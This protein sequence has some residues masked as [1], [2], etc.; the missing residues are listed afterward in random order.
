MGTR[1]P[2]VKTEQIALRPPSPEATH[3]GAAPP[4][5]ARSRVQAGLALLGYLSISV[6]LFGF[7]ILAH[8]G[9]VFVGM[10]PS[11]L[12]APATDPGTFMWALT[13][14]PWAVGHHVNPFITHLVWWPHGFNMAWATG[15]PA[16]ALLLWPITAAFGPVVSYNVV[17][18]AAPGLAAWT[19]FLLCRQVTGQLRPSA[20]GGFVFGFSSYE[21]AHLTAHPNFALVFPIPLAASLVLAHV[22]GRLST[23]AFVGLLAGVLVLEFLIG[24][25]VF[26]GLV[27]F[28]GLTL[29]AAF[30]WSGPE[31]RPKLAATGRWVV[32]S[33]ALTGLVVSPYLAYALA[34]GVRGI[35]S[36]WPS[37]YSTDLANLVLPTRTAWAGGEA[38]RATTRH[39][40]AGIGEDGAYFGLL[41]VVVGGF[42]LSRWRTRMG[43]LLVCVFGLS[44]V[45]SLG[46]ELHVL[47]HPVAPSVWAPFSR[48]PLIQDALPSRF[49]M[50]AWLAAALMTAVWLAEAGTRPWLR[51][52]TVTL[53]VLLLLPNLGSNLWRNTVDTPPFFTNGAY[54][55][56]VRPG[57]SVLV[58]PF[59]GNGF[60]LLWQA[61]EHLSFPLAGGYLS[62]QA[63]K[64]DQQ[65]PIIRT[66]VLGHLIPDYGRELQRFLGA[67]EVGTIVLQDHTPGPWARLFSTLP[68][69]WEAVGGVRVYRLPPAL[70]SRYRAL[71]PDPPSVARQIPRCL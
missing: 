69:R 16:V 8:P 30:L 22:R 9:S 63:P 24:T 53:A 47:G 48:L 37:I 17:M 6:L 32:A 15:V 56:Y 26:L 35:P 3:R 14:W 39:T 52:G 12:S 51:W 58:V 2:D 66:L 25:E 44:V 49:I 50:Y 62:C 4:S 71:A 7:P 33:L 11:P 68:V 10:G 36:S 29:L 34:G 43:K 40:L 55:N 54:R 42:A 31:L 1:Q 67:H 60:S 46:P 18:L 23:R 41:L 45:A 64:E 61:Q 5:P 57:T 19:A 70:L 20:M 21:L 38:L 65:Y 59:G 28:G 27:M 13:W